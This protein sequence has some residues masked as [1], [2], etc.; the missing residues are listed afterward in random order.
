GKVDAKLVDGGGPCAGAPT[1]GGGTLRSALGQDLGRLSADALEADAQGLEDSEGDTLTLAD[2]AE[3]QVLGADV[4]VVETAGLFDGELDDLLGAGRQ[5][6]L[7][8]YGLFTAAYDELDSRADFAEL[9]AEVVEYFGGNAIAL[10]DEAK[11]EM[12]G[13]DV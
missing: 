4:A 5:A 1:T 9:D 6:D 10:A 2:E 8:A 7:A 12:L 11:K 13:A 3:E